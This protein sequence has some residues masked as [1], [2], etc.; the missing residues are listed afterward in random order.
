MPNKAW[1]AAPATESPAA[2]SVQ[3]PAPAGLQLVVDLFEASDLDDE[4]LMRQTLLRCVAAAGA[5]LLH[6]HLHRFEA[7]GG[8][9]G[10]AVLAE[11]HIA[12]HTWPEARYAAFDIFMCGQAQPQRAVEVLRAA[13]APQRIDVRELRRGAAAAAS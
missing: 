3:P 10:V 8:L 12:V 4:G 5:R 9:S 7:N 2:A 11:S 1:P 13:F 6:I